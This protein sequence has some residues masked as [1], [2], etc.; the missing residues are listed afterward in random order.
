M[1]RNP[2]RVS[3]QA[4][5]SRVLI[6]ESTLSTLSSSPRPKLGWEARRRACIRADQLDRS[7]WKRWRTN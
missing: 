1:I 3:V 5:R 6:Q 4:T 2:S 7:A